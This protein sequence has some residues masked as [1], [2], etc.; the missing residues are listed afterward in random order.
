MNISKTTVAF[1]FATILTTGF[2]SCS[3]DDEYPTSD[4]KQ[5]VVNNYKS[6]TEFTPE[7]LYQGRAYVASGVDSHLKEA[8]K[9]GI[10]DV[11][12]SVSDSQTNI[13]VLN[14]LS[15]LSDQQLEAAFREGKTIAIANPDANAIKQFAESHPW[16]GIVS[17]NVKSGLMLFTFNRYQMYSHIATPTRL[18]RNTE[19][20]PV[21]DKDQAD[22]IQTGMATVKADYVYISGWLREMQQ[23]YNGQSAP[24][25][26][27]VT[28]GTQSDSK[29]LEDFGNHYHIS[30]TY[31]YNVHY[32]F[33]NILWS[34]DD[35]LN[36]SGSMT[37]AYD[38]YMC[39]VYEGQS[40]AGDY[41]AMNMTTSVANAGMWQGTGDNRHGGVHVRWCGWYGK[42]FTAQSMLCPAELAHNDIAA[43]R[44]TN[45]Q[46]TAQG[47]P[48]PA[49]TVG[50]TVYT[51]THTFNIGASLT[52]GGKCSISPSGPQA[53]KSAQGGISAGWSWT[54][55]EQ[56]NIS[57]MDIRNT[58]HD[59]VASWKVDFNNLPE[60]SAGLY[61]KE[62][63]SK[64]FRSTVELRS[65]WLWYDPTGKDNEDKEPYT[66]H[67]TLRSDY[68]MQSF[69][70][71]G[72]DL[73]SDYWSAMTM[74]K[75]QLPK[76]VNSTVG[77]I[78]L[79]N[80]LSDGTYITHMQVKDADSDT[81]YAT[82]DN[83]ISKG[84]KQALGFF[85]T[86]KK[87]I[88]TFDA[89]KSGEQTF[90]HYSYALNKN[91]P[92]VKTSTV[93]LNAGFDFEETK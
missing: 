9:N 57:D 6:S 45:V 16:T 8:L 13:L 38:I 52:I 78:E 67:T 93:T 85:P 91:V 26:R 17:E 28:R 50:S 31:P 23:R 74:H 43:T 24:S 53:E 3:R 18:Q 41:Y 15:D 30:Y 80:D 51:N 59:N 48:S 2:A 1:M 88:V 46:F 56:R 58:S 70:T 68:E 61:F 4:N 12:G 60:Y 77:G 19:G 66:L 73:K 90:R 33:R 42:G 20:E 5:A 69:I 36:G 84:M 21:A 35:Y 83:S 63:N 81:V 37:V 71:T 92:L 27:A 7:I 40:G 82:F 87:Y 25:R 22:P 55:S 49:T 14:S 47:T 72:A 32:N 44:I 10:S 89:K 75:I 86:T 65:S 29:T 64:V 11:S 79:N 62:G 76:M 54:S 39:H 34:D